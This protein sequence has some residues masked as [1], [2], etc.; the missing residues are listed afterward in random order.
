MADLKMDSATRVIVSRR[1]LRLEVQGIRRVR[2][3][4]VSEEPQ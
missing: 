3:S 2:C 1:A 4:I